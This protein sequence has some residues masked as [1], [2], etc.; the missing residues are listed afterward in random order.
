MM[1]GK[2]AR[3]EITF[4]LEKMER[5]ADKQVDILGMIDTIKELETV[6]QERDSL[7]DENERLQAEN[8]ALANQVKDMVDAVRKLEKRL[9]E[10]LM[11]GDT[12]CR[13]ES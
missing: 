10:A 11:P 9:E 2:K 3:R 1:F 8:Y 5:I 13:T 7:Y 4:L 12:E 6:W